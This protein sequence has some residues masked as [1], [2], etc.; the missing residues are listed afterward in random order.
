MPALY[1]PSWYL[2]TG[3]NN[4]RESSLGERE[5]DRGPGDKR[6]GF[7]AQ[8]G[9]GHGGPWTA[10]LLCPT[11][12]SFRADQLPSSSS[13]D[14]ARATWSPASSAAGWTSRVL[15]NKAWRHD[16]R[17]AGCLE[18]TFQ[19]E[20]KHP[21]SSSQNPRQTCCLGDGAGDHRSGARAHSSHGL[22]E[23]C[24]SSWAAHNLC[25]CVW[26]LLGRSC[27]SSQAD[28]KQNSRALTNEGGGLGHSSSGEES[29]GSLWFRTHPK[30]HTSPV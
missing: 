20:A 5:D 9:T 26:W 22:C 21:A 6:P 4:R 13:L 29:P 27:R 24:P 25:H 11:G 15:A 10:S 18:N 30:N 1:V 16:F 23:E 12:G 17:T 8:S 2:E 3:G 7:Q 28:G 14:R 19:G